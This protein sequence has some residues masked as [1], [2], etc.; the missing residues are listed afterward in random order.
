MDTSKRPATMDEPL[1]QFAKVKE[2]GYDVLPNLTANDW[3]TSAFVCGNPELKVGWENGATTHYRRGAEPGYEILKRWASIRPRTPS[4]TRPPPTPLTQDKLAFTIHGPFLNPKPEAAA[5]ENSAFK[6]RR[7]PRAP[8]GGGRTLQPSYGNE[9]LGVVDSGDAG[10]KR[11][12]CGFLMY[13]TGTEQMKTF[14]REMGRPVMNNEAMDGSRATRNPLD[15]GRVCNEIVN[16]CVNQ[17][18][19]F[20]CDM[21]GRP[22]APIRCS[23]C[24]TAALPTKAAAEDS[25]A[26]IN[27]NA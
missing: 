8:A 17:A 2:N 27:E 12:G 4:W 3:V 23:P 18:V 24:G 16:N 15:A 7:D 20:R 10:R 11:R 9:W 26:M 22:A 19:P 6:S 14:C 21:M 25:I 13:I 5:A 1:E